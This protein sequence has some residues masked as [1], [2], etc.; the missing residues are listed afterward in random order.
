MH[1]LPRILLTTFGTHYVVGLRLLPLR[2]LLLNYGELL[3]FIHALG[4]FL[5]HILHIVLGQC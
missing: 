5:E 1:N 2:R 4:Q 3:L